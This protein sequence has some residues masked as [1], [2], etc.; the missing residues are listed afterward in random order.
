MSAEELRRAEEFKF[1]PLFGADEE[2][3]T[4]RRAA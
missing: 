2:P 3:A 1:G 4:D